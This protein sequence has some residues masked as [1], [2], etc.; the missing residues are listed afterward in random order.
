MGRASNSGTNF[1]LRGGRIRLLL[2]LM[3]ISLGLWI[4]FATL[5]VPAIIESAYRGESWSFLNRM[6]NGQATN[7][8]VDYLQDWNRLAAKVTIAGLLG[9]LGFWLAPRVISGP[10]LIQRLPAFYRGVAILT[11]NTLVILAIIQA[12]PT[13]KS[14]I[15]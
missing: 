11:L 13:A 14:S 15:R 4:V 1:V 8:V 7:P 3:G 2:V 9:V 6:I 10:A 12:R 5:V